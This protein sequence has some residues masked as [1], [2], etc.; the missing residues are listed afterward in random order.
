MNKIPRFVTE[1][2][3]YQKKQIDENA[4]MHD[5]KKKELKCKVVV[6]EQSLKRG[7]ITVSECMKMISDVY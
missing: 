4:F 3:N 5:G 2:A 7:L 6:S 1:Y